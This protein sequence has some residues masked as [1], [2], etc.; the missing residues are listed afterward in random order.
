MNQ[1]NPGVWRNTER[2]EGGGGRKTQVS[3]V[4]EGVVKKEG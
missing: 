1:R 2:G 4:K 3:E